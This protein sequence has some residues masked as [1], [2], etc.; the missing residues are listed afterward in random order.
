MAARILGSFRSWRSL[1]SRRRAAARKALDRVEGTK[2]L[3]RD[4]Y[5][6]VTKMLA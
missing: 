3:S 5:E 2:N 1:E 6:I 4:T